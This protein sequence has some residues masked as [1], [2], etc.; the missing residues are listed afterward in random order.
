MRSAWTDLAAYLKRYPVV[1]AI[2]GFF[3]IFFVWAI[4]SYIIRWSEWFSFAY[5]YGDH[6]VLPSFNAV[7]FWLLAKNTGKIPRMAIA[8][9]ILLSVLFVVFFEPDASS[10][11]K[12]GSVSSIGEAYHSGFIALEFSFILFMCG[13][14]PFL[15]GTY[16][17]LLHVLVLILLIE[18]FLAF[19][20][21]PD[22][23]L[24]NLSPLQSIAP[25]ALLAASYV[26]LVMWRKQKHS[27]FSLPKENV[28]PREQKETE[29]EELPPA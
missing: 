26:V 4:P 16:A 19:V 1:A 23:R 15:R 8:I 24:N 27:T 22:A 21:I 5:L 17:P 18:A 10:F 11:L 6:I 9:P 2:L 28:S 13:V 12:A 7:S 3:S 25:P 29:G 14:Y 20:N